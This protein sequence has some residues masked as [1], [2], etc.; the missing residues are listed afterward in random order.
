ML[1]IAHPLPI[2]A[3][4]VV[5]SQLTACAATPHAKL[6]ISEPPSK[7]YAGEPAAV[8]GSEYPVTSSH[9]GVQRGDAAWQRGELDLA[10][11]LYVQALRFDP[12]DASTLR[13]IGAIHESRNNRPLARQAFEMALARDRYHPGT[14]ERL[15]LI[16]LQDNEN[17]PARQLLERALAIEPHRWRAHNGLGV[18]LDRAGEHAQALEHYDIALNLQPEESAAIL[19]NRGYSKYL[20]GDLQGAEADLRQALE[21]G[22]EG[23]VWLNLGRVQA[24]GRAYSA[25]LKSFLETLDTARAYNEAG[26]AALRNGDRQIAR[27]YF[28]N[29]MD[30]SPAHFERA[31][32]NL[33]IAN[34]PSR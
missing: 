17:S 9:D 34:E 16:Y 1:S 31:F 11:Y 30:A 13:K 3:A 5:A 10:L 23:R 24:Q 29:A 20:A 8:H 33:A 14:L 28:Q 6:G 4:V 21:Q 7:L 12:S 25:A 15:G 32:K 26:E 2:I 22:A 27:A 19:N 18:L